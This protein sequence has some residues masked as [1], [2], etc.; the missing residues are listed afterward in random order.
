[1]SLKAYLTSKNFWMSIFL[2]IAITIMLLLIT[3]FGLRVYT[4][5]GEAYAVPDFSGMLLSQAKEK[6]AEAELEF[7]IMDSVYLEEAEPGAVID[8]VP[9]AG[10]LVKHGRTIFF[11]ICA[12]KPEQVA[13]PKLTDI[14]F[15]Q[16]MNLMMS[17]GLNVGNVDYVPSE[18]P[19]L[20]LEQKLHGKPVE[21]GTLVNKGA[22]IDL[23]V[24]QNR[25][26]ERTEIPNLI[27]VRLDQANELIAVS[28]L[29]VGAVIYDDSFE[30]NADSAEARVWQQRPESIPGEVIEQGKSIDLWLTVDEE[31]LEQANEKDLN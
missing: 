10:S 12:T 22:N 27:G 2:A 13:M 3:M 16:A 1:M 15:R 30:S 28:Y 8:Q 18:F 20:V 14:S 4:N 21:E 31:K 23:T 29:N 25:F 17:F 26:G 9:A 24:G 6:V 19:N 5:H 7:Q 11:T